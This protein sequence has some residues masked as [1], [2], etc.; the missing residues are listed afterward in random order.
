[1]ILFNA[2]ELLHLIPLKVF[3]LHILHQWYIKHRKESFNTWKLLHLIPPSVF[4]P[5]ETFGFCTCGLFEYTQK[6]INQDL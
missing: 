6:G 3:G 2:Q 5:E 4:R 1:M